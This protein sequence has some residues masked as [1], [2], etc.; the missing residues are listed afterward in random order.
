V[1]YDVEFVKRLL[2]VILSMPIIIFGLAYVFLWVIPL[3][4]IKQRRN[5]KQPFKTHP[6]PM[7]DLID[8]V[9]EENK[10]KSNEWGGA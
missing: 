5:K 9:K 1:E 7:Q 4:L 3:D 10:L 2:S 8:K 6:L